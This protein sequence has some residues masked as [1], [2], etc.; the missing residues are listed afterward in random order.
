MTDPDPAAA[1]ERLKIETASMLGLNTESS[2]LL[3]NLQLDLVSLLRLQI[4]DLQGKVLSGEQVDLN[5]LSTA[6]GMLRQ[7][8]PVNSLVSQSA[9]THDF[10]GAREEL[11]HFLDERA[12]RI[13]ALEVRESERLRVQVA[14][15]TEENARL[16]R[17]LRQ[18]DPRPAPPVDNVIPIE[19]RAKPPA[20]HLQREPWEND[21]GTIAVPT[22]LPD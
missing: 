11:L 19:S 16:L 15:L 18:S 13:E 1:Y 9:V 6:L 14:S 5:R 7:L 21:G 10:S 4:D 20:R 2:S 3:E 8:L 12:N 17:A 22:W